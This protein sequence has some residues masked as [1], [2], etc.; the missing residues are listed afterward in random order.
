M[1]LSTKLQFGD[2]T[3]EWYNKEYMV[4]KCSCRI[5]RN[6]NHN[7]PDSAPRCERIV[8]TLNV[9][10]KEDLMLY[11]WFVDQSFMSGRI[12]VDINTYKDANETAPHI[13][14]FDNAQCYSISE[15][16]DI[17]ENKL[18]RITLELDAENVRVCDVDYEHL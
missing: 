9:P 3:C 15:H 7:H 5:N 6:Y 2:N 8:V 16:Y 10:V 11:E 1:T 4:A 18:R 12:L 13:I 17:G 14:Y